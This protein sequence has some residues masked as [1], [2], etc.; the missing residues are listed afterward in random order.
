MRLRWI[1]LAAVLLVAGCADR[2]AP[3]G[4][5]VI[6]TV[7]GQPAA[8]TTVAEWVES[9]GF[10]AP[11]SQL[12]R[13]PMLVVYA[14]GTAIADA[15]RTLALTSDELG[16]LVGGLRQ[17]LAGLGEHATSRDGEL[18]MDASTTVLRVRLADGGVQSVSAYAL[19][20]DEDFGFAQRLV[21]AKKLMTQVRQRVTDQ[22]TPYASD[23][24]RLVAERIDN[25][26]SPLGDWP[27][28][29]PVPVSAS[30]GV[31]VIERTDAGPVV[32]QWPSEHTSSFGGSP[33]RLPDGTVVRVMW[34]Y[35][36]PSE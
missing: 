10:S 3:T 1:A 28:S 9:G 6:P 5:V 16:D 26:A 14:D 4:P 27:A 33:L 25:G 8:T 22:G 24:V 21:A 31:Y 11:G 13:P 34:R 2:P 15:D 18:V 29:V 32:A 23:Q 20:V 36:L 12:I 7:S 17:D 30:P 19:F 35:L